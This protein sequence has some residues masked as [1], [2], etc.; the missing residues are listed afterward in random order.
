MFAEHMLQA[1]EL[2]ALFFCQPSGG[3]AVQEGKPSAKKRADGHAAEEATFKELVMHWQ[4]WSP[5]E[6]NVP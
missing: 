4:D 6:N 2:A 3:P 5:T 1:A